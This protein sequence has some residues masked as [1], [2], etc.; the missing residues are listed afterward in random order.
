MA[1]AEIANVWSSRDSE[2][3]LVRNAPW[4]E[5]GADSKSLLVVS[6][7]PGPSPTGGWT[8]IDLSV[9]KTALKDHRAATKSAKQLVDQARRKAGKSPQAPRKVLTLPKV[10]PVPEEGEKS[11]PFSQAGLLYAKRARHDSL[12]IDAAYE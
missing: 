3:N 9:G 7:G 5:E 1:D 12:A 6:C 11:S 10:A 2:G 8:E 4:R